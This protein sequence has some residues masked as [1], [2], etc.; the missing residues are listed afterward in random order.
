MN[1][2]FMFLTVKKLQI[3][4]RVIRC[5]LLLLQPRHLYSC[6]P[7]SSIECNSNTV[8]TGEM[9]INQSK[10]GILPVSSSPCT[11]QVSSWAGWSISADPM[12]GEVQIFT[13]TD[14]QTSALVMLHSQVLLVSAMAFTSNSFLCLC[15]N[16]QSQIVI[17]IKDFVPDYFSPLLHCSVN[18]C[19]SPSMY[20]RHY[21]LNVEKRKISK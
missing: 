15:V 2:T 13:G 11:G 21:L 20:A 19:S 16:S 5:I 4:I 1:Q 17:P 6:S 12:T 7:H 9:I 10:V 8:K 14:V 18:S 3:Q